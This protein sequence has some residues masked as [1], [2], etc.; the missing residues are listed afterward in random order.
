LLLQAGD[1]PLAALEGVERELEPGRPARQGGLFLVQGGPPALEEAWVL[2]TGGRCG[3]DEAAP[4]GW[5]CQAASMICSLT[6]PSSS[7][8][9][10][11]W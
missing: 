5:S 3:A 9:S 2:L 6:L 10:L 11:T 8:C 1:L 4:G 7:A